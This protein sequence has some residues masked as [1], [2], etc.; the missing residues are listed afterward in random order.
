[1]VIAHA[2]V[3]AEAGDNVTV[4]IDDQGGKNLA[5]FE[6]NRLLRLRQAG[7]PVGRLSIIT[8]MTVLKN[9]AGNEHIP[10][11][12]AMRNLYARLRALDDGLMPLNNTELMSLSCWR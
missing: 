7:Y 2:V 10:N 9:A 5:A 12:A 4:L 11:R 1:M 8:T 3:A 6:A